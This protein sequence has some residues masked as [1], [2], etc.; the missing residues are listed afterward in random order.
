M[1]ARNI[2]SL[3]FTLLLLVIVGIGLYVLFTYKTGTTNKTKPASLQTVTTRKLTLQNLP[4]TITSY[5]SVISP[6]MITVSA[7]TAGTITSLNFEPGEHV[8]QG[9]ILFTITPSTTSAPIEQLAAKVQLS[10]QIYTRTL[11]QAS[12]AHGGVSEIDLL[13]NKIQYQQDLAQYQ[14]AIEN[15]HAT[16]PIDG[17]ITDTNYAEGDFVVEGT[18]IA[19]LINPNNIQ[20]RFQVPS[21]YAGKI[22]PGQQ[23][24]FTP[25]N[26]THKITATIHYVSPMVN[27][28]SVDFTVRA[29]FDNVHSGLLAHTFG[30]VSLSIKSTS[31]NL[32]LPQN[33]VQSDTQGFFVFLYQHG[34][35]FKQYFS[36]GSVTKN[37][38]IIA[39]SGLKPGALLITTSPYLLKEGEKV[40][41]A[42]K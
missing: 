27:A 35:V 31:K 28:N 9:Q 42:Q 20:L 24:T 25:V 23:V 36:A 11:K 8:S 15:Y 6:T 39:K 41:V 13:K 19:H 32:A 16:A 38:F 12:M 30:E 37:G 18:T 14:Q 40:K 34:K 5:G 33:L 4:K 3:F 7:E 17:V 10:R 29:R 26:S 22:K 1:Q 2:K 21:E